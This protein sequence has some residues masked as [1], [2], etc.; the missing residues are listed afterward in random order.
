[1]AER[2]RRGSP[3][4]PGHG[5]RTVHGEVLLDD[6]QRRRLTRIRWRRVGVALAVLGVAAGAIAV[7]FSPV[8]RV[9]NVEVTT[10]PS[11][12]GAEVR[13]RAGLHGDSLLTADLAAAQARIKELPMVKDATISRDW[14]QTVRVT[15]AERQPW[16]VWQAGSG[17]SYV[18]DDE[19][20]VLPVEA[21]AGAPVI[22]VGGEP[23]EFQPG[24]RV[25]SDAVALA[26]ALTEQVPA[27]LALS[28]SAFEWADAS[29]LTITTDA[30]Y[31]VVLGDS[32]NMDYK[33]AVWRAVEADLG[34]DAMAGHVLDLRFGD[35]PSFQ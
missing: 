19:G 23:A 27:E 7:Y 2:K 18:V 20:V 29:G 14:P 30:G 26:R 24:D 8:L 17:A 16:A 21:P 35:R 12:D 33:L 5:P 31:R 25:D 28:V 32:Q 3:F 13:E 34:R 10:G 6:R 1:V 9:Q 11:V 22:N 4:S 15:V